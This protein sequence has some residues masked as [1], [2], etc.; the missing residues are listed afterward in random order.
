MNKTNAAVYFEIP[1]RDINRAMDFYERV[2]GFKFKLEEIDGY[3]MAVFPYNDDAYGISG[4]LVKGD[5]YI[6][7]KEG[8]IIYFGT[9]NI[10][11]TLELAVNAGGNVLYPV[12]SVG[13]HGYV[14]EFEDSEGNR[15][16]LQM[17]NK[18]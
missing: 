8:I 10:S 7:A 5:V 4:A 14:A 15:I 16:A 3:E 11:N 13:K 12:K 17:S 1:V 6:P 2:F 18:E 9:D